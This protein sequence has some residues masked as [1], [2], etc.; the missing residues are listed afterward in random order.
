MW[1]PVISYL[2]WT[3]A[4]GLVQTIAFYVLGFAGWP[5]LEYMLHRFV[6]HMHTETYW[7]NTLHFIIHGNHHV[8]PND[9]LR[10]VFPPVPASMIT[11]IIASMIISVAG[12]DL[13]LLLI[14]GLLTGYVS[15]DL[16]H[17]SL[18]APNVPSTVATALKKL[19]IHHSRHH[20]AI[21]S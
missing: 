16:V 19:K 8:S 13:G 10:L 17:F 20:R 21:N 3:S 15:Y 6:F 14:A 5:A 9:H 11:F 1:L 7:W 18:H 12:L 2:L 4:Y